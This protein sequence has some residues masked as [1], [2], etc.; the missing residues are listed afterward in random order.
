MTDEPDHVPT[1]VQLPQCSEGTEVA[2]SSLEVGL[3]V[4]VEGGQ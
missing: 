3:Q 4:V 2:L 1:H